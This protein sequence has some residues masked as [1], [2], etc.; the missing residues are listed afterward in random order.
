MSQQIFVGKLSR[1]QGA[2]Y[3]IRLSIS[4]HI[5]ANEVNQYYAGNLKIS[6]HFEIKK[7]V[8]A[9]EC[10]NRAWQFT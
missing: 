2:L 6:L 7:S 9:L 3:C 4:D 5:K 10:I 8:L 1:V